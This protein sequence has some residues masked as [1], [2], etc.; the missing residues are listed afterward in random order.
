[1]LRR[2]L[3][4]LLILSLLAGIAA[5]AAVWYL[6]SAGIAPRALAMYIERRAEGHRPLV[7]DSV[8]LVARVLTAL[9]RGDGPALALPALSVGAQ[10]QAVDADLAGREVLLGTSAEVRSA[11]EQAR[12]GD[13]L[14]LLPGRY[15]FGQTLALAQPGRPDSR[16][17]LRAREPGSVMIEFDTVQGFMVT[18][19][20]WQVENLTIHGTCAS[21]PDCEHAFHV[22]GGAQRF[23]ALNNTIS[24]FNAH[25]KIN[26]EE[27]RFPDGGLIEGNTLTN[28]SVRQT[29]SSVTPID[30]VG[31]NRW[32]VRRNLISDFVKAGGD[33]ISY[34]A[35]AKGGGAHNVFEGNIVLCEARLRGFPG[36]R[37]GLSLGG[38]GTGKEFC[39]D[40]RCITEQDQSVI[41]ANLVAACSDVG[42]YLNSAPGSKVL[43]NTL[44]DTVG[45]DVRFAETVAEVSGNL[46]DG[47]IRA[48]NGAVIHLGENWDTPTALLY[49]GYHPVRNLFAGALDLGWE[50]ALPRHQRPA[51][52]PDLC[53]GERPAQAALGAF[54]DFSRCRRGLP[55]R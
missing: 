36:Q 54:E 50:G 46:V 11:I 32:I 51:G 4:N 27:G 21:H 15:R 2:I 35:F 18:G 1:M 12:P 33:R 38:G 43:H 47:A 49:A 14:T 16:I 28:G 37:V 26:G 52:L 19:S 13:V 9:D 8:G 48:R 24:D 6:Q 55:P 10:P 22:V 30:M 44:I 5:G 42:I 53:G 45:I 20:D 23:A 41:Q 39:R 29:D 25:F 40:H 7:V 17:T 34:G 3:R 31:V